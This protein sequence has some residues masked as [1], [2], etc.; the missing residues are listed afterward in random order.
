[1]AGLWMKSFS[2][3]DSRI[4]PRCKQ[5]VL[6]LNHSAQKLDHQQHEKKKTS[7]REQG[8]IFG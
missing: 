5:A 8:N 3:E 4:K 2:C 6:F 7:D 1:M